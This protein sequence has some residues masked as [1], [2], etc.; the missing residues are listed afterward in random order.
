MEFGSR[1]K[2][3]REENKISQEDLAEL[4]QVSRQSVSKWENNECYPTVE[5]L[6]MISIKLNVSIDW[7]F[8]I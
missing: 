6:L 8:G 5:K 7:L 3:V 4:V 2:Q 1:L